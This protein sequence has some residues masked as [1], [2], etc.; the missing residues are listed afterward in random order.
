MTGL[1]VFPLE[2]EQS[3]FFLSK[4]QQENERFAQQVIASHRGLM[5]TLRGAYEG[6]KRRRGYRAANLMIRRADERLQAQGLPFSAAMDDDEIV[7]LAEGRARACADMFAKAGDKE[8]QA[9]IYTMIEYVEAHGL[10]WPAKLTRKDDWQSIR[11]KHIAAARR[12]SDPKWW[13]RRLRTKLGRQVESVA[14][15]LGAVRKGSSPYI[16]DW[17]Y[18]RWQLQQGRNRQNLERMEVEEVNSGEVLSLADC[19]DASVS[20]PENRRNE[21]MVR[22]R[23]WEEVATGMELTGLFLTLTCPSAYHCRHYRGGM[24]KNYNGS[25]PKEAADYLA[26]VWSRIRADWGREG[27]RT[28]GFRVCEPHHDGTPH[29]HLWLFFSPGD[30]FRAR[31]IFKKHA[32]KVDG[33]E[34]GADRYRWDCKAIDPAKGS[35]SGYIAKYVAKNIDGYSVGVDEEGDCPGDEGAARAR[36]WA[37]MWGI[38]QFQQIGCVSVTVWR[39]LR[40]RREP[41]EDWEPEE[42]EAVRQAADAGNWAEFVELMGG[43]FTGR[44]QQLLRLQDIEAQEPNSYGEEVKR[45]VGVVMRGA[46]RFIATRQKI[47]RVQEAGTAAN[48]PKNDGIEAESPPDEPRVLSDAARRVLDLCQ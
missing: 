32:L 35:A 42:I 36:A 45:I 26:G 21:L 8:L 37:S 9:V 33:N 48:R 4:F 30:I 24:N 20:N 7:T 18:G 23:G 41:L 16:S 31:E 29:Y 40:R 6:E 46:A 39:E 3:G 10:E 17:A 44:D 11:G 47:W 22:M 25:S 38:R 14:R 1:A 28:F 43:A 19:A 34:E 2:P 27:I 15:E 13:R 12:V 5:R